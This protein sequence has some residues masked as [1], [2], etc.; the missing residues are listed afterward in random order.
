MLCVSSDAICRSIEAQRMKR[1]LINNEARAHTSNKASHSCARKTVFTSATRLI[2]AKCFFNRI[3]LKPKRQFLRWISVSF[4]F[5][6][7]KGILCGFSS[8]FYSACVFITHNSYV[9][10]NLIIAYKVMFWYPLGEAE[11]KKLLWKITHVAALMKS[12]EKRAT[13]KTTTIM[14]IIE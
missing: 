12:M 14:D 2:E 11:E 8:L 13:K 9:A 6:K 4:F 7:S 10:L 3:P 5:S 1:S